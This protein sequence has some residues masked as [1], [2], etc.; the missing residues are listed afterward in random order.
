MNRLTDGGEDRNKAA[1][2]KHEQRDGH[3]D[4]LLTAGTISIFSV[5]QSGDTGGHYPE[6]NDGVDTQTVAVTA[7]PV[8]AAENCEN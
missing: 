6:D 5:L 3:G 2:H 4:R 1:R 8:N 7:D